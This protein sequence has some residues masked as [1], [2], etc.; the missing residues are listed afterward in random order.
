MHKEEM[1]SYPCP[2]CGFLTFSEPPG[3]YD[4]CDV[5]GWEDDHVQLAHPGMRGGA[6]GECLVE[7]QTRVL[8]EYPLRVRETLGYRRDSSWRPWTDSDRQSPGPTPGSGLEY[9]EA[10]TNEEPEYYWRS[11]K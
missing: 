9:F 5:C 7:A 6:N 10:A 1:N 4:I 3:S 8:E 2:A 11:G